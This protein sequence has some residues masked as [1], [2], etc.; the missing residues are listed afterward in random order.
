MPVM[1]FDV[2][3]EQCV[4]SHCFMVFYFMRMPQ[5]IYPF[6]LDGHLGCFQFYAIMNSATVNFIRYHTPFG[7]C[8]NFGCVLL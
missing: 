6:V 1:F 2:L 5:Y 7:K 4:Y 8:G 3:C